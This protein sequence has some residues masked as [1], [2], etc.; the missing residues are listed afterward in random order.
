[1]TNLQQQMFEG[2]EPPLD[3]KAKLQQKF[4]VP[5]FSVLDTRQGYWQDR[6]R[7]WLAMGIQSEI[8]REGLTNTSLAIDHDDPKYAYMA[9]R[10]NKE[11]GSIF[12]PVLC[13][14]MYKW[15]CPEHGIIYDP[16]AG[17]SVR[18]IVASM[19]GYNYYGIDLSS[20]Q[21]EANKEQGKQLVPDKEP[22]W[23]TGDS[24]RA[25]E[26]LPANF[27]ADF[28]F[29]CPPYHDLEQYTDD[30]D[31]ISNMSWDTFKRVYVEIIVKSVMLLKDNR[32][33]CFVVSEIRNEVG[34]Y[35][36]LVPYTI[37]C[38]HKGGMRYY[39]EL[40]LVNVCGSLPVRITHQF[41]ASRKIGRTHQ[42]ILI[43]YKGDL[44]LI[45]RYFKNI[46]VDI[47]TGNNRVA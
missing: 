7:T 12:D 23:Y 37:D 32:F 18:G 45:D 21:I 36:G 8:G 1:M 22:T 6:K 30:M 29:S 16:F 46:K 39:N 26:L 41:T 34:G 47:P 24:N 35:K 33:A 11:G 44:S 42:N 27:K 10:G 43:F 5:P 20:R 38:F 15:F 13:E 28:I 31:D 2:F 9:N 4:I 40:I 3:N 25:S 19:L 17:G 14:L